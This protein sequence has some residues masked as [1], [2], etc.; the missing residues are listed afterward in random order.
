MNGS[1]CC[2]LPSWMSATPYSSPNETVSGRR[3][4]KVRLSSLIP[5]SRARRT[6][7]RSFCDVSASRGIVGWI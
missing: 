5:S 2:V 1:A 3:E 6:K 4:V 7:S